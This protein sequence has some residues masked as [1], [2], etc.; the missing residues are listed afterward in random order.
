MGR[1]FEKVSRIK[2]EIQLP[3]RSTKKS[4]GYDFYAIEDIV[5]P[6]IW[7]SIIQFMKVYVKFLIVDRN[8][9]PMIK[10]ILIKTGVKVKMENDEVL[11]LY[12]RS[13]NP[14]K[15]GLV[16][17]NSVGVIDSDYYN[18]QDNEGEIAFSYYN[19]FLT[20]V[21]IKK[22]DKIGQGIFQKFLLT[23]ND[24]AEGERTGGFGST[25]K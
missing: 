2:D 24:N 11:Y 8:M 1:Y 3:K 5:I 13:S 18:N 16:L 14:T 9:N 19:F 15:R 22:G 4:A 23:D 6:S 17:A 20:D 12:N 25:S 7:K 10:P 21:L